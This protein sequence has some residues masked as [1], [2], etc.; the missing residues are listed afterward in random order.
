MTWTATTTGGLTVS[1][2]SGMIGG[3]GASG[4]SQ[5]S[6]AR[7][8][9]TLVITGRTPGHAQVDIALRST[10]G[11]ALPPVVVNVTVK[12]SRLSPARRL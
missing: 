8:L 11:V 3:A 9:Q 12:G 6:A 2:S 5:P 10:T 7:F 4:S 1:P